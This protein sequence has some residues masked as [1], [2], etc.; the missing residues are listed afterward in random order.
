MRYILIR[1]G[2]T[3]A[4]RLTRVA[5]GRRGASLNAEG[6]IQVMKLREKLLKYDFDISSEPVAVSELISTAQTAKNAGL[7]NIK[8]YSLLNE[9]K[10]KD[11]QA[12]QLLIEKKILPA[13]AIAA[14]KNILANP[15]I[16]RIWVTHG[17]IIAAILEE[18]G[19]AKP[20]KFV[21]DFCEH[22]EIDL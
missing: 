14:A 2:K 10:T 18:L 17:L 9:V 12:T 19:L 3:D 6:I 20:N 15:P 11:P 22:V 1:H 8:S 5:Y 16:E 21:I 13:E 7:H 4:N